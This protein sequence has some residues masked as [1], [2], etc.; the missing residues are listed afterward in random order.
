[1]KQALVVIPLL[2]LLQACGS[3]SGLKSADPSVPIPDLSAYDRVVVLDF[4]DQTDTSR[5]K[6]KDSLAAHRESVSVASATFAELLAS[7]IRQTGAFAEVTREPTDQPAVMVSG[8]ITRY[9]E[10][11]AAARFLIGLGAGSS[12][13]DAVIEFKD[14]EGRPLGSIVTDQNSWV[15]GGVIAA[16]Q[17]VDNFMKGAAKKVAE[18]LAKARAA[19]PAESAE[20]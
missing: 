2:L 4:V 19:T 7:E 15:G 11:N 6:K 16:S 1:M 10:G 14:H 9:A 17:D 3:T 18:E 12:Y 20:L 13:F 8:S 5:I